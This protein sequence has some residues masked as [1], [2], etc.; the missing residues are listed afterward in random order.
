MTKRYKI[1]KDSI[2]KMSIYMVAPVVIFNGV[3]SLDLHGKI[4]LLPVSF[5]V[6]SSFLAVVSYAINSSFKSK[7][8]RGVLA[9]TAGS[10]NTGYF[11]LPV[12][13]A[14]F[15]ESVT[16]L[17]VLVTFG[18]LMYENTLGFYLV[19][20]GKHSALDS[21]KKLLSLPMLYAFLLAILLNLTHVKLGSVYG[22]FVPNFRGAYVI[23][24]SFLVGSALAGFSKDHIDLPALVRAFIFKFI[25]YPAV[26]FSL[27]KFD[28]TNTHMFSGIHN[29]YELAFLMS[30]VPL[31]VNT[32]AYATL[33]KS[34]PEKTAFMVFISTIFAL[35]YIPLLVAVVLPHL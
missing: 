6:I 3:Y 10:G 24:G 16:G 25:L 35:A 28:Q 22:S 29:A 17:A 21:V 26:V 11:G 33:L 12:A 13:I 30:I 20:R 31:A 4:L 18:F 8:L 23:L 34:E 9:F 7:S 5:F 1:D 19:A 27:I 14:V 2:V 15:G 32:V